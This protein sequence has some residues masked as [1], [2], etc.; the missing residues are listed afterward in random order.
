M[1]EEV[2]TEAEETER[3][4]LEKVGCHSAKKKKKNCTLASLPTLIL[5]KARAVN[6]IDH[7][8]SMRGLTGAQ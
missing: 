8:L 2:K 7:R 3:K 6:S 4:L 5:S 1:E